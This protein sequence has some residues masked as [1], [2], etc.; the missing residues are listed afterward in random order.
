MSAY[1]QR[2]T[3]YAVP[4]LIFWG[5]LGISVMSDRSRFR[6]CIYLL[7]AAL[8]TVPLFCAATGSHAAGTAK[9]LTTLI[10]TALLSVPAVLVFN[11]VTM[12]KKEGRSLANMLSFLLGIMIGI[13]EICFFAF[14]VLPL[15]F[16]E[17]N[18]Q[19]VNLGMRVL[20]FV[21]LSVMYVAVIFAS[22]MVYTVLL[23]FIPTRRDFDFIII[24]G[25]G[26]IRGREVSK[27]LSDRIDKAIEVYARCSSPPILI[28]SGGKGNDEEISEA[29]AMEQYLISKGIP[30]EHIIREDR[31]KTTR[32]NL[33][34]ESEDEILRDLRSI[35]KPTLLEGCR[36][37]CNYEFA[38]G[39]HVIS[40]HKTL[41]YS[42]IVET[43]ENGVKYDILYDILIKQNGDLHSDWTGVMLDVD[44]YRDVV[45]E[46]Y[47]LHRIV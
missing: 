37:R 19:I 14:F 31:S 40:Y 2:L 9:A 5:I 35:L 33:Y 45:Y 42:T 4:C 8:S 30:T 18:A 16:S 17:Q 41:P 1:L 3:E 47:D 21:S 24:H 20:L 7:I 25:S 27:L 23:Q 43:D 6:N 29:E 15:F 26:L 10:F 39:D 32:E 46:P 36:I 44:A 22:F 34:D 12:F 28:P 13:G 11:G 38:D